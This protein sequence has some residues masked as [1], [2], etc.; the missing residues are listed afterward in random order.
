MHIVI[1]EDD[2]VI[3]QELKLLLENVLY[4]VTALD[5]FSDVASFVLSA[6]PDLVLLDYEMP[7]CNGKQVLEMLRSENSF[8]GIPVIFL[9][10]RT[11]PETVKNL[12]SMRPDGYLAKYLKPD[13]IKKK[14]DIFFETRDS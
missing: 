9:T 5:D 13:E 7:V 10:G 1:V 12:I 4:Q 11:D 14:I 8:A 6:E 3:R 2:A